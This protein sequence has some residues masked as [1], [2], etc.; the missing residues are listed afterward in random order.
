MSFP[1]L[2]LRTRNLRHLLAAASAVVGSHFA[3]A[4][5]NYTVPYAITTLAGNPLY[6][7]DYLDGTGTGAHFSNPYGVAV[8]GSGNVYVAD[9]GNNAIRKIT[10]GGMVTTLAGSSGN[11]GCIDG[12]GKDAEWDW[13]RPGNYYYYN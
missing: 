3:W 1:I 10:P 2:R 7:N 13:A 9:T 12:T 11:V 4:Q 6:F 5:L 8:D